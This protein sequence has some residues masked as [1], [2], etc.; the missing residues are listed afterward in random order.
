M[1]G[2]GAALIGAALLLPSAAPAQ[3]VSL[4]ARD[5]GMRIE[6]TMLGYD[7]AYYRVDTTYGELTLDA[8]RVDCTGSGCPDLAHFVPS[9]RFSGAPEIGRVLFPALIESF[10]G[11]N[12]LTP[13]RQDGI[14]GYAYEL[15]DG[16]GAAVLRLSFRRTGSSE[17][18]ADLISNEADFALT[19]RPPRPDEIARGRDAG[20]GSLDSPL[21]SQ[22]LALDGLTVLVPRQS[23]LAM[24]DYSDLLAILTESALPETP[25]VFHLHLP[26]DAGT[27]AALLP[28]TA[29]GLA[30]DA[31]RHD[32]V[33]E[34]PAAVAEDPAALGIARFSTPGN[35]RALA[36]AGSCGF[37]S[38]PAAMALR[39]GDYP[40]TAPLYLYRPARRMPQEL[41][42]FLDFLLSPAAQPVI[43]RAGYTDQAIAELPID[44]Q[45]RRLAQAIANA[46]PEVSLTL[47]QH[48]AAH[49]ASGT[50]LTPT[51]RFDDGSTDLTALSRSSVLLL[52]QA[53]QSGAYDGAR[54]EFLG[55]S[56]GNGDAA[57]NTLLA[58]RRADAVLDAV[59]RAAPDLDPAAISFA[60]AS[61]GEA[62]PILCDQ[63]DW[64]ARINRRVEVWRF[65]R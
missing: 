20:I 54:I 56:D 9:A 48:L 31:V 28:P 35:A 6:G 60:T 12:G 14:A 16:K 40:L 30:E 18:F 10:A 4:T 23:N 51:F 8:A 58:K 38:A 21:Q 62:L 5:G 19:L 49:L 43:R 29:G 32:A 3:D 34:I 44:G 59:R 27:L 64:G 61:Y 25:K 22:V 45:G 13:A 65:Q 7:G 36:I 47:L 2:F 46:G 33:A 11:H 24:I 37:R 17:A 1:Q 26:K 55:F 42:R 41:R 57:D 53:L 52:A 15:K 50:R 39:T 63:D